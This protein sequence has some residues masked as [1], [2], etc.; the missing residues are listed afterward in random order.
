MQQFLFVITISLMII[1][2]GCES[3]QCLNEENSN[4]VVVPETPA[5]SVS[6]DS[7]SEAIIKRTE[8]CPKDLTDAVDRCNRLMCS[9]HKHGKAHKCSEE[10]CKK[11]GGKMNDCCDNSN[12]KCN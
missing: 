1:L 8:L 9:L 2:T 6:T 12:L 5:A 11:H 4:T 3:H 10:H 7:N